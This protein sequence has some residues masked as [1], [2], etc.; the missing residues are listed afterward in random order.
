M[1][2]R[3]YKIVMVALLVS[4]VSASLI[5][6]KKTLLRNSKSQVRVGNCNWNDNHCGNHGFCKSRGFGIK[7]CSCDDGSKIH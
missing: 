2:H 1:F 6:E 5:N 4:T 7:S 3:L